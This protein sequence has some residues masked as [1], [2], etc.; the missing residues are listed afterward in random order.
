M[1]RLNLAAAAMKHASGLA[2]ADF[3]LRRNLGI[4]LSDAGEGDRAE[5]DLREAIRLAPED[6]ENHRSLGRHLAKQKRCSEAL[7][8]YTLALQLAPYLA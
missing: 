2:P 7:A 5:K 1:G 8:E 4:L 6:A 3:V